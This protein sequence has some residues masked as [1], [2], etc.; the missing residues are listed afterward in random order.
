M[1]PVPMS[2]RSEENGRAAP[3]REDRV[4]AEVSIGTPGR[5]AMEDA[6]REQQ[7]GDGAQTGECSAAL[8]D[9]SPDGEQRVRTRGE[10][11]NSGRRRRA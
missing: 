2:D 9:R 10:P 5:A 3:E 11:G 8:R 4:E 1:V 6:R 7:G